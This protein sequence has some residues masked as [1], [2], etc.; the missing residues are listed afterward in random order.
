MVLLT[1]NTEGGKPTG[2]RLIIGLWPLLAAAAV[3]TLSSYL[4]AARRSWTARV[5]ALS[6]VVLVVGS[7]VMEL[8]VVLPARSGRNA[9]DAEAA[10]VLR[11]IGDRVIVMDAL[12]D[13]EVGGGLFYERKLML[14]RPSQWHAL[15][16]ALSSGQID[17][18]TYIARVPAD[19]PSFPHYRRADIWEPG[20][21]IISRWVRET[22]ASP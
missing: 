4:S 17:R 6:G 5:T 18:F 9:E 19:T 1:L 7:L 21:F 22:S 10:R 13:I 20:R 8:A 16:Q 3:E 12:F 2:P 11:A 15:S 14:G